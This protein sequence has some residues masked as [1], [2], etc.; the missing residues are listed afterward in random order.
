MMIVYLD[1][2]GVLADFDAGIGHPYVYK[3]DPPEMLKKGFFRN[4]PVVPGAKEAVARLLANP[5]VALFVATKPTT[6]NLNCTL[7]K[8]EWIDEHFPELLKRMFMVCDKGL[9]I[10]DLLVDDDFEEWGLKFSGQFIHFDRKAPLSS[11]EDAVNEIEGWAIA[12]EV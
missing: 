9:L 1:M 3:S 8:Y 7:E 2:D 12:P 10:G 6:K 5:N 11:W 4:L